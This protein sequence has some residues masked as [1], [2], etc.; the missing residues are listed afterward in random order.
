V[1]RARLIANPVA[2]GDEAGDRLAQMQR[3]LAASHTLDTVLTEAPGDAGRAAAESA[4]RGDE[5]LF[6]AGGDGTLNEAVNGVSSVPGAL[7]RL[8]IGIVPLGT[9]NDFATALGIPSEIEDALD[10]LLQDRV[11]PVDVGQVN[12]RTFV[13]VSA[14]GF[15]AEVSEAVDPGL[16][17]VAGR[18]AYLVGGAKVLLRA[19][20]FQVTLPGGKRNALLFAVCNAPMIGG[21]RLIA[22]DA[23]MDDGR[24]DVCVVQAMDLL[25]FVALLRRVADGTHIDDPGVEY[26]RV[27]RLQLQFDRPVAVN[28]DGEPFEA[29]RCDYQVHPLGARFLA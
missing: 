16:K 20:P 5:R 28:A 13:N 24:L 7:A 21:G 4:A 2:G 15:L 25:A 11:R 18:L 29:S 22:P 17:S 3:R 27:D 6:V 9:G 10:V 8:A 1:P 19:E 14:G 26:F 12:D 23:I